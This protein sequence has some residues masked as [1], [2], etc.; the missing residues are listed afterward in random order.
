MV[1]DV[2]G[3]PLTAK[4]K[5]SVPLAAGKATPCALSAIFGAQGRDPSSGLCLQSTR[6]QGFAMRSRRSPSP[7]E[8][9]HRRERSR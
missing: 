8:P 1:R 5:T 3:A 2:P 9:R 7:V 4:H 6:D